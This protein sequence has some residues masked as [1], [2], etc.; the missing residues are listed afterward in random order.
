MLGLNLVGNLIVSKQ[1]LIV[2]KKSN[3]IRKFYFSY[4]FGIINHN[5]FSYY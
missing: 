4:D 2:S 5:V 1:N 3:F